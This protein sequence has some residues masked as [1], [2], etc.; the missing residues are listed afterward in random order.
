MAG[1]DDWWFDGGSSDRM[2]LTP[3]KKEYEAGGTARLQVRMPFRRA[4]ALVTV[5]REGVLRGFV[6]PLDGR[7]PIVDVTLEDA[8]A[9]NVYVSVLAVRG[10]VARPDDPRLKPEDGVTALV[11]LNKPAFRLGLAAL[12]VGWKPNRLDVTVRPSRSVYGVRERAQVD[13]QVRRAD[14]G[15][16]PPGTEVAFAAV[17][18]GLLELA[19][20][21]SWDLLAA[22]MGERSLEVETYTAQS[23]VVGKRHHG[24]KAVPHG[25]GGGRS[26]AR[27]SFDTL[28]TWQ[29]RVKVGADGAARVDVPI[30][31]SLTTFRLVA[32]ASGGARYFGTGS[33]D[34]TTSQDIILMSGLPPVVRRG[35]QY[36]ATFTVRN[37]TGAPQRVTLDASLNPAP[38]RGLPPRVVELAPGEARDVWWEVAAPATAD[39]LAWDVTARNAAGREADRLSLSQVVDVKVPVTTQQATLAQVDRSWRV[40]V[41]RPERAEPGR[42]GVEVALQATLGDGLDGVREYMAA[43]PYTCIEQRVSVALALGEPARWDSVMAGVP[44]YMDR[45]G[46]LRYFPIG[47]LPGDDVLTAY[48][49]TI[50]DV[51]GRRIPDATRDAMLDGLTGFLSGRYPRDSALPTA[52]LAVRR[53]GAIAALAR[54]GRADAGMLD[55]IDIEPNRWPTSAVLDW[56]DILTRVRDI[57]MNA[58]R[59]DEARRILR[60][61]VTFGGSRIGF[62]TERDDA[63]W[64]LMSSTDA[65]AARIVIA[66]LDDRNWSVDSPRLVRGL[67]ARQLR[68]HWSTTVANAWGTIAVGRFSAKFEATPVTGTSTV[69]LGGRKR[70]VRWPLPGHDAP[71]ELPWP[72]GPADLGVRHDGSGK[73][74]ALVSTRA[75]VPVTRAFGAGF[76]VTRSVSAVERARPDA[77]TRGDIVRVRLDLDAQ[78]DQTWVVVADPVPAGATLLGN[79]LGGQSGAATR[80]ESRRGY[81]WL[82]YTEQRQGEYR[83]YY[84]YV[85]KGKWRLEYTMRLDNPGTFGL[86]PTRV[87]AMYAP[88]WHAIS[89]NA[90]FV[91]ER[92]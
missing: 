32:V 46:L 60:S 74:W 84:R 45:A 5:E 9:P 71:V 30:N 50:A 55:A 35:D 53:L 52:D 23:Q 13:V 26:R 4:T 88:D 38:A 6:Q 36:L 72:D 10:R 33:A 1:P 14:G 89:P 25:G 64:W 79:G 51:A 15:A 82:A 11:D 83:A 54:Y 69:E 34:I 31:D 73:P 86:P 3:D 67:L 29:S 18:A 41:A 68:G 75:A 62:S 37:T 85:P 20:N 43:Y 65:N 80:G 44:A 47:S 58:K 40:A 66:S 59:V 2:D 17:D 56:L 24:R 76:R 81:A 42:G 22:M 39:R 90:D 19:P 61:R 21:R 28:L 87:E 12:R 70:V 77:W 7:S 78:S 63:L 92:R 48:V 57:P 16:L 91:I 49:L 8:D 27:Q